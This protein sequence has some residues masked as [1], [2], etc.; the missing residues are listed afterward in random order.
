[1]R[2]VLTFILFGIT[3]MAICQIESDNNWILN[4]FIHFEFDS[5]ELISNIIPHP[6]SELVTSPFN[7]AV[8]SPQGKLLFHSSGCFV[9]DKNSYIMENGD[10]LNPG[11]LNYG[12][13]SIGD[14]VWYQNVIIIP[15]PGAENKYFLFT[16]DIGNPFPPEDTM[17][18]PLV[19]LHLYYHIIDMALNEGMGKV[20]QKNT[21]AIQDTLARGYLQAC[22][23]A[24]GRDWWIVIPEWRS[25]CYYSIYLGPE[26][27]SSPVKNCSG[28]IFNDK[29]FGAEV[30][31]SPDGNWYARSFA[32]GKDTLGQV[33]LFS[34][35][36]CAGS[37]IHYSSLNYPIE[38]PFYTGVS[39]SPNS[40]FLYVTTNKTLWQFNVNKQNIQNTIVKAGEIVEPITTEKGGLYFQQLTPSGEIFVSSPGNHYFLSTI[41]KPNKEGMECAFQE[42]NIKYPQNESNYFGLPNYPNYRLGPLDGSECDSLEINNVP[43]AKF[44]F[45]LVAGTQFDVNF[46][47]LSYFEP[48]TFTWNFGDLSESDLIDPMHHFVENKVYS[49]CLTAINQFGSNT[50]CQDISFITTESKQF[51]TI[52]TFDFYPNPT[53]NEIIIY[54]PNKPCKSMTLRVYNVLGEMLFTQSISE[55]ETLVNLQSLPANFYYLSL[56]DDLGLTKY[57]TSLVKLDTN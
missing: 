23:H 9:M 55:N 40:N 38:F 1:M 21:I 18:I 25:N 11:V 54:F 22:R 16:L 14:A 28:P 32:W 41:Q 10:S 53:H 19:P 42:H 43:V 4:K 50:T 34:F 27:L 8:S 36:R 45:E 35:D 26:G 47:N 49:V 52:G 44:K 29:D 24:N 17:Y 15:F 12:Y 51:N 3:Q 6:N 31:F 57:F 33:E 48:E 5:I 13:C 39:F 37:I 56:S 20:I 30:S 7:T 2:S 46:T